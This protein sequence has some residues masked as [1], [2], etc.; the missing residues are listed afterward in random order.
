MNKKHNIKKSFISFSV[1]C[2][3]LLIA[4]G[5][6]TKSNNERLAEKYGLSEKEVIQCK[7]LFP[8]DYESFLSYL[9]ITDSGF[10]GFFKPSC[11]SLKKDLINYGGDPKLMLH[12]LNNDWNY[13][14]REFEDYRSNFEEQKMKE[15]QLEKD[16][17]IQISKAVDAGKDAKKYFPKTIYEAAC[18]KTKKACAD[19]GDVVN[20]HHSGFYSPPGCKYLAE[21]NA[22]WGDI[23]WGGWLEA[24]FASFRSG[25]SYHLNGT[26]IFIDNVAKYQNG[27]GAMQKTTTYCQV[28]MDKGEAISVW[29]D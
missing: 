11:K 6:E 27:F 24:N 28:D 15:E 7:I 21:Q 14:S 22:K 10:L 9:T 13:R 25:N 18:K 4:G 16:K 26:I 12:A 2:F 19:N 23:D 17:Q 8:E 20:I 29:V 5:S 1:I 3:F